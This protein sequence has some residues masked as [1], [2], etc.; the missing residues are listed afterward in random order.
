MRYTL[1]ECIFNEPNVTQPTPSPLCN[2]PCS[3]LEPSIKTNLLTPNF[4]STYDF[5]ADPN[6]V[7]DAQDCAKC[8]RTVPNQIYLSNCEFCYPVPRFMSDKEKF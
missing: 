3:A 8:Y 1:D 7:N 5:C 2:A 4:S 6:F